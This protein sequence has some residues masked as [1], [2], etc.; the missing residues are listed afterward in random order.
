M[1]PVALPLFVV[2]YDLKI[3]NCLVSNFSEHEIAFNVPFPSSYRFAIAIMLW[4]IW[5]TWANWRF[6]EIDVIIF[7]TYNISVETH[8]SLPE[9]T[10]SF[11]FCFFFGEIPSHNGSLG[12]LHEKNRKLMMRW[13]IFLHVDISQNSRGFAI[14]CGI[15]SDS[16]WVPPPTPGETGNS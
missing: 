8:S 2:R 15:F 5:K 14:C 6:S 9:R 13:K 16:Y 4:V 3:G 7:R 12:F 1:F 11:F 10:K